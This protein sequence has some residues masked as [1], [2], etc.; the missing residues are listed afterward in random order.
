MYQM[1]QQ[2]QQR[3]MANGSQ[4]TS[5]VIW[6]K[7]T[8]LIPNVNRVM[9]SVIDDAHQ[10]SLASISSEFDTHKTSTYPIFEQNKWSVDGNAETTASI[11]ARMKECSVHK[12]YDIA[13]S[14]L[15]V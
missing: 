10:S 1:Y 6:T 7:I 11:L 13:I 14:K 4:R 2:I 5:R 15:V 12:E 3:N 8:I 9:H